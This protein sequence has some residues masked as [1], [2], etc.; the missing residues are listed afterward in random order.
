[1]YDSNLKSLK[2]KVQKLKYF[3]KLYFSEKK[4]KNF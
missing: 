4:M 3:K 1:M 2:E